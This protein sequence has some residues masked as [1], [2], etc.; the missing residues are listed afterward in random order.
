MGEEEKKKGRKNLLKYRILAELITTDV[1]TRK[2]VNDEILPGQNNPS[3][4]LSGEWHL[5]INY[6]TSHSGYLSWISQ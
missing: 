5:A 2:T 6:I 1:C 3:F 4:L